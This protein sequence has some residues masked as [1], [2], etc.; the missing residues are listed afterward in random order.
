MIPVPLYPNGYPCK[1]SG[2]CNYSKAFEEAGKP[3]YIDFEKFIAKDFE[4]I[5]NEEILIHKYLN[6]KYCLKK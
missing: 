3:Q 1:C 4:P 5:S 2:N 6:T